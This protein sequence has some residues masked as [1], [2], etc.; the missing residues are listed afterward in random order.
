M[1][2]AHGAVGG[3]KGVL[4]QPVANLHLLV[5]EDVDVGG[6]FFELVLAHPDR[7]GRT[8][9]ILYAASSTTAMPWPTPTHM[10][11]SP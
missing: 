9:E 5:D 10:A 3:G 11:A 4:P 8:P 6:D 1:G 2:A 7:I